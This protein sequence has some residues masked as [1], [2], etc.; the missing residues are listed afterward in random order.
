LRRWLLLMAMT[1]CNPVATCGADGV[2]CCTNDAQCLDHFGVSFPFCEDPG[3]A[4]GQCVE[5][6]ENLDCGPGDEC[7]DDET[8]GKVC[9][10]EPS[11]G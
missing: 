11:E 2:D 8:Y 9:I 10:P 3:K 7:V 4:T 6:R 1:G 5:C